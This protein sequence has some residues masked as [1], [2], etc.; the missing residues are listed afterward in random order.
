MPRLICATYLWCHCNF[1]LVKKLVLTSKDRTHT[2]TSRV[3]VNLIL[4]MH[5]WEQKRK[6]KTQHT[7][8]IPHVIVTSYRV[9]VENV[10]IYSRIGNCV[11]KVLIY[12][13]AAWA[14]VFSL[15][16]IFDWCDMIAKCTMSGDAR[17]PNCHGIIVYLTNT[18][19]CLYFFRFRKKKKRA[20][21]PGNAAFRGKWPFS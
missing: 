3:N 19:P 18:F 10:M 5:Y 1:C 17:R 2:Q 4:I 6:C 11:G 20:V 16:W 15:T 13:G 9:P 8:W 14:G 7:S 12:D 21:W